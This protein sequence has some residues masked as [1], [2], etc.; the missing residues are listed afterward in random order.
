MAFDF[1][2]PNRGYLLPSQG[3][4]M[5]SEDLPRLITSFWMV[6]EDIA[7]IFAAMVNFAAKVHGHDMAEINGLV[8][9]LAGKASLIHSHSIGSLTGVDFSG[10]SNGQFIKYNG[11]IFI[12]ASNQAADIANG[13][14][15]GR[16]LLTAVNAATARDLIL[17]D[18]SLA[19]AKL[20]A[21][22]LAAAADLREA[23][24]G[25]LLT[26]DAAL[27]AMDWVQL[28]DAATI[29]V[30]HAA[31]VNRYVTVAGNRVFGAPTNAKPGWPWNVRIKQDATGSRI[32]TWSAAFDFGDFGIPVLSTPAGAEDLLAFICIG[33]G[34]F[35][36][37]GMRR[38]VD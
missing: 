23:N 30:D 11:N 31:G 35:A 24:A 5:R 9:A 15:I 12:P 1:R 4:K 38:R 19:F 22:A 20:A 33:S 18:G 7:Q 37:M 10:A 25:K 13:T 27:A 32:P 14:T 6:D 29:A 17:P 21:A 28:A 26:P 34:K 2:T 36:F 8:S 16:G 3:N